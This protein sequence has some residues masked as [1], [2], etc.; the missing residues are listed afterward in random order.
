MDTTTSDQDNTY[1]QERKRHF[2]RN[3]VTLGLD[4]GLYMGGLA[5]VMPQ[6]ILPRIIDS[7]G[8]PHW[9]IAVIPIIVSFGMLGPALFVG[10]RIQHLHRVKPLLVGTGVPQRLPYL[11]TGLILLFIPGLLPGAV[12]AF[13]VAL[14]P[15][16]SGM[17]GGVSL[18]AFQEFVARTIPANR[19]PSLWAVRSLLSA[20]LGVF[21]GRATVYV[22]DKWP[23]SS[24]F[25]ILHMTAFCFLTLS[26]IAF[27]FNRETPHR[28]K[29]GLARCRG[30]RLPGACL[31]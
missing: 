30:A 2:W 26:Y 7:L 21:A 10:H 27:L 25:G 3:Y 14:T 16:A 12:L 17:A 1:Q 6:T 28:R 4:G 23:G 15:L 5:F 11:L 18:T 20:L 29:A 31:D 19:I 22:L 9:L 8:G 13:I 24:G